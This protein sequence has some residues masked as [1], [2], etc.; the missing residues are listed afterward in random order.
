MN[1]SVPA[2]VSP[3]VSVG[4]VCHFMR[5]PTEVRLMIY[6][7]LLI[8]R[9]TVREHNMTSK[10]VSQLLYLGLNSSTNLATL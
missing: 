1:S 5:L 6:R 3:D 8:A 10:E 9:Y 7:Y 2:P 4:Q